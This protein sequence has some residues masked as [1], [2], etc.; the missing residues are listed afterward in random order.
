MLMRRKILSKL[1]VQIQLILLTFLFFKWNYMKIPLKLNN[2][3]SR[4]FKPLLP[5]IHIVKLYFCAHA[6]PQI[7]NDMHVTL[8]LIKSSSCLI[9]PATIWDQHLLL[10]YKY[11]SIY[12]YL[13]NPIIKINLGKQIYFKNIYP[14][15]LFS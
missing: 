11:Y 12:I 10:S 6:P 7:L 3:S 8:S 15:Q 1:N 5:I 14:S 9:E 13:T 2:Q 4:I